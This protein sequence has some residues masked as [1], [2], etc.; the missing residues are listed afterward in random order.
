MQTALRLF[1][2]TASNLAGVFTGYPI[3]N[4]PPIWS[5]ALQR[6]RD[7]GAEKVRPSLT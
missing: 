1:S 4:L 3:I 5:N 6:Y 2:A 7:N